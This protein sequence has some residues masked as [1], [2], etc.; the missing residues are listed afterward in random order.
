MMFLSPDPLSP[1]GEGGINPYAYC[2]GD[3]INFRDPS[4]LVEAPGRIAWTLLG[5]GLFLGLGF[6]IAAAKGVVF[7]ATKAIKVNKGISLFST[8]TSLGLQTASLSI[9]QHDA[10]HGTDHSN[11]SNALFA[12]G[13]AVGI[14]ALGFNLSGAYLQASRSLNEARNTY[15]SVFT[16][17]RQLN[18]SYTRTV[19]LVPFPG[20]DQRILPK[21]GAH[22]KKTLLDIPDGQIALGLFADKALRFKLGIL[23]LIIALAY[24]V[25]LYYRSSQNDHSGQNSQPSDGEIQGVLENARNADDNFNEQSLRLRNSAIMEIYAGDDDED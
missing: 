19:E 3:P 5:I 2:S 20:Y 23:G 1:F 15:T 24:T 11:I 21:F 14:V 25:I 7:A 17:Q 8:V 12:A 18:G 13:L 4:G 16:V 10:N 22:F 6:S 9:A